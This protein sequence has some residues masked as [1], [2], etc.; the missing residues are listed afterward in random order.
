M[1]PYTPFGPVVNDELVWPSED[2]DWARANAEK[3]KVQAS[4]ARNRFMVHPFSWEFSQ[5]PLPSQAGQES[6]AAR[7]G[8]VVSIVILGGHNLRCRRPQ[9]NLYRRMLPLALAIA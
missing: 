6:I 1:D 4:E 8:R 3:S 2:I 7:F 9:M 5:L